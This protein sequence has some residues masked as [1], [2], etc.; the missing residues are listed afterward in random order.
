MSNTYKKAVR[1]V[2]A[3][4]KPT[5]YWVDMDQDC[6]EIILWNGPSAS[7]K[8]DDQIIIDW[9]IADPN[10]EGEVLWAIGES[11]TVPS[12]TQKSLK[13]K[14]TEKMGAVNLNYVLKVVEKSTGN[15]FKSKIPLQKTGTIQSIPKTVVGYTVDYFRTDPDKVATTQSYKIQWKVTENSLNSVQVVEIKEKGSVVSQ[16]SNIGLIGDVLMTMDQQPEHAYSLWVNGQDTGNSCKIIKDSSASSINTFVIA[17]LQVKAGEKYK[18]IW[19]ISAANDLIGDGIHLIS[20][21]GKDL[22]LWG[23]LKDEEEVKMSDNPTVNWQLLLDKIDGTRIYS[24]LVTVTRIDSSTPPPSPTP[25]SPIAMFSP[26]AFDV[27]V[28]KKYKMTWVVAPSSDYATVT[29]TCSNPVNS[30][31]DILTNSRLNSHSNP[32]MSNSVENWTLE[33]TYNDRSI[34]PIREHKTVAPVNASARVDNDPGGVIAK[35]DVGGDKKRKDQTFNVK[36]IVRDSPSSVGNNWQQRFLHNDNYVVNLEVDGNIKRDVGLANSLPY[37]M[38]NHDMRFT[39]TVENRR[40]SAGPVANVTKIVELSTDVSSSSVKDRLINGE[41]EKELRDSGIAPWAIQNA[42]D[43][44]DADRRAT[45]LNQHSKDYYTAETARQQQNYDQGF[46]GFVKRQQQNVHE[47]NKAGSATKE[48]AKGVIEKAR[49]DKESAIGV[50]RE[51]VRGTI[52]KNTATIIETDNTLK[53]ILAVEETKRLKD[54]MTAR[55]AALKASGLIGA[56]GKDGKPRN[57]ITD[58]EGLGSFVGSLT[59]QGEREQESGIVHNPLNMDMGGIMPRR[60]GEEEVDATYDRYKNN[61]FAW[62]GME[63]LRTIVP[64]GGQTNQTI[65]SVGMTGLTFGGIPG[66]TSS[67]SGILSPS[68]LNATMNRAQPMNTVSNST[69]FP[70]NARPAFTPVS[71]SEIS[72]MSK[73]AIDEDPLKGKSADELEK[74][75]GLQKQYVDQ[76]TGYRMPADPNTKV[77]TS[78]AGAK[79]YYVKIDKKR[80]VGRPANANTFV[81]KAGTIDSIINKGIEAPTTGSSSVPI[82]LDD[83]SF[84]QEDIYG[85]NEKENIILN[86]EYGK[87]MEEFY[88][89]KDNFS[90]GVN[91]IDPSKVRSSGSVDIA[92]MLSKKI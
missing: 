20:S 65:G 72:Q 91:I 28:G 47:E 48:T 26:N 89:D 80:R 41:S 32:T 27:E 42:K 86:G 66:M 60:L 40:I 70:Q 83:F 58:S 14:Y 19:E 2:D 35:F 34:T 92:S 9:D 1:I 45:T 33:I 54:E 38:L 71:S 24:P 16:C 8:E 44:I 31:G 18:I 52:D 81:A 25:S 88:E 69:D 61:S 10:N 63:S 56:A 64:Q 15:E 51:T 84:G 30:V 11:G 22:S 67:S 82:P 68:S 36:W 49:Q 39:L 5:G 7:I 55:A 3:N 23:R 21:D 74:S 59:A 75:F 57:P 50:A 29:V 62:S 87:P 6:P 12:F 37:K 90:A 77:F 85:K 43:E 17:P 13:D 53:G 78:D 4:G 79:Y 73:V 46:W 76:T